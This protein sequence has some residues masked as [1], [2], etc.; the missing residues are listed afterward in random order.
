MVRTLLKLLTIIF[1]TLIFPFQLHAQ[2]TLDWHTSW[3]DIPSKVLDPQEEAFVEQRLSQ[4]TTEEKVAQ[5]LMLEHNAL[6]AEDAQKFKIGAMLHAGG[7]AVFYLKSDISSGCK[8][9][10]YLNLACWGELAD[11]YWN[12][13][14]KASWNKQAAPIPLLWGTDAMHGA[15]AVHGATL[16]PHNI[17]I[18]AALLGNADNAVLY[19]QMQEATREQVALQGFRQI[20]GPAVSVARN[21]HWGRT[22][23]SISE[24]PALVY[25]AAPFAVNGIQAPWVDGSPQ[26]I[27]ATLKHFVGDGGTTTGTGHETKMIDAGFDPEDPRFL[28]PRTDRG[29]N[30]Y[31]EE[32]LINLHGAG[33]LSGLDAG[34]MSVM[35][36]LSDW[37]NGAPHVARQI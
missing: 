15:G 2:P 10:K 33:Y 17:G 20:F 14:Q 19:Q 3:P 37:N 1:F 12:A 11:I 36:S 25:E 22:Y 29:L 32:L 13:L 28:L 26:R 8:N 9:A 35:I 6:P 4:M 27:A 5:M 24:N 7:Q 23:E 18:G 16:F 21:M 31:S 30:E 34:A